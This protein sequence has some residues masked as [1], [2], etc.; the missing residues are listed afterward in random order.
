M[1]KYS[2]RYCN[3]Y[4]APQIT[5][6]TTPSVCSTNTGTITATGSLGIAP[7]QYSI[8]GINFQASTLFSGLNPGNYLV[9]VKDANGCMSAAFAVILNTA[10]PTLNLVVTPTSC[11]A[12][13]GVIT[14]NG[15]GGAAPLQYSIDGVNYQASTVFSSL[16]TGNYTISV[17]D[18]NGCISTA[19]ATVNNVAGLSVTA[20]NVSSVCTTNNGF[21]TASKWWCVSIAHSINGVTFQASPLFTNLEGY[22]Y[23]YC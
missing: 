20:T 14:A 21:I 9:Q 16:A 11:S 1:Y 23:N 12:S 22:L 10:A 7:L 15:V 8:N 5:V 6:T 13:D 4:S 18:A 17:K 3:Q 2:K 19:S